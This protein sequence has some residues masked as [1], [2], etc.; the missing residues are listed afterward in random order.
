[1]LRRIGL[2]NFKSWRAL[3]I[4]LAPITLLFGANSSGKSAIIQSLLMLKQTVNSRDPNTHLNFGG[5]PRDYVDLGSYFDLVYGHKTLREMGMRLSWDLS[6]SDLDQLDVTKWTESE[7]KH[8]QS[9]TT[10]RFVVGWAFDNGVALNRFRYEYFNADMLEASIELKRGADK[11]YQ[12]THTEHSYIG[13]VV[14]DWLAGNEIVN[15]PDRAHAVNYRPLLPPRPAG[16]L[17]A[18]HIESGRAY[19]NVHFTSR[20]F[21][22][23]FGRLCSLGPLRV[24]PDRVY[25]WTGEKKI[26]AVEQDGSDAIATLI[27]SAHGD[28]ALYE[29]VAKQLIALELV[30]KFELR[31]VSRDS[32]LYEVAVSVAEQESSLLD[33]GF[34]ISQVLP[35]ITMLL[36]APE[37]SIVLLEQPELHLHP[38]AQA[39]LGDLILQAAE[40]RNLQ[41]IVESHSEHILRRMQRRIAEAENEFATPENVKAYFCQPGEKGSVACEVELDRF[42]QIANW[43]DKF[44]GDISGD[45]HS[46]SRAAFKRLKQ[47]RAGD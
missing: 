39:A 41:L 29:T 40:T 24:P 31:P 25:L 47:E 42:G 43:P 5:G 46:M 21:E 11:E 45:I 14:E 12:L 33:A 16:E 6:A 27:S 13:E 23:Y 38:N 26:N 20:L 34:G 4:E 8:S 32:R 17:V 9:S 44:L 18:V 2:E 30:D 19:T 28:R 15:G 22:S 35:V 37:G 7:K 10:L 36:S 3:D 1:M